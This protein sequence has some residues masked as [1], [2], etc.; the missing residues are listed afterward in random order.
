MSRGLVQI[1]GI[2]C[3]S[4]VVAILNA[5]INPNAPSCDAEALQEG[6][7]SVTIAQDMGDV[8][9][10]DARS[11]DDYAIEHIEGALLLN[12]DDWDTL[13]FQ[14]LESWDAET[15][16]IVYCS[17]LECQASH[18]V[19]DRLKADLGFDEIY[20]LKGGWEAWAGAL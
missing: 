5:W 9:F 16:I 13:L 17:S 10:L 4:A 8:V 7:V 15:P 3:L 11:R 2:L 19:A 6:E 20:V 18:A 12:E 14:F 1:L